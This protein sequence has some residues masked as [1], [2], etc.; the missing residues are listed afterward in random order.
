MKQKLLLLTS[1]LIVL[2]IASSCIFIGPSIKG[3]GNVVEESRKTGSFNQIEVSRG[4]N[5]YLSKGDFTK[6]VVIA[7]ENLHNA[8]ETKTKGEI[9]IIRAT[10]NVRNATSFK[11]FVTAPN[12][13]KIKA[14]S[15]SNVF[16]DSLLAYNNLQ[17]EGS[18]GSNLHLEILSETTESKASSG[19]NINLKGTTTSFKGKASSGSNVKA[20]E[21]ISTTC[22]VSVSSG[23]NIWINTK[24]DFSGKASSGGNIFLYGNPKQT[25]LEKSSGG[26]IILK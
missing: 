15:G 3:N 17:I 24:N 23:A 25:N 20:M 21:L 2:F 12:L 10:K 18:S 22:D 26:N 13:E 5:V 11:V 16:S 8:I 9:L 14:T 7:D 19:S 4:M 6:I 1:F